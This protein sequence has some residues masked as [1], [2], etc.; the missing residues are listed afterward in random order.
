MQR[1]E[2]GYN[3]Y[4]DTFNVKRD[5]VKSYV[6]GIGQIT[7][8]DIETLEINS[9]EKISEILVS[10]GTKVTKNQNIMKVTDGNKTRTI[11]SSIAGLFF[12]V[13]DEKGT[14]YCIYN[15]DNIGV[16]LLLPERDIANISIGQTAT[17][18][19][20][21]LDKSFTGKV[22]Y[23]SS[24]PQNDR[25]AVR[26]KLEYV[27]EIKFGY[28]SIASILTL[29][30]ENVISIPY[31][32]LHMAED[33]RYYVYKEDVKDEIVNLTYNGGNDQAFRTYIEVGTITSNYVEVKS[34][35]TEGEI[36][37]TQKF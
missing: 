6:R 8:F 20:T 34:G 25:Y 36:I 24:L 2:C 1:W 9:G 23:V 37:V 5:D 29:D 7:S 14:K 16:K 30:K 31:D 32:Y 12:C 19:I 33:G 26:I 22:D 11:K 28:S 3:W 4:L 21:A 17:V 13:E 15:T 27:D 10:E 35:L 18:D